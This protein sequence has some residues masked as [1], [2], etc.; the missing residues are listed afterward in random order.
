MFLKMLYFLQ[1]N[2]PEDAVFP[3]ESDI[4]LELH[5]Y[6]L[7]APVSPDIVTVVDALVLFP[8]TEIDVVF[9]IDE[10]D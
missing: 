5:T 2:V 1:V 9:C 8:V 3:S 6:I 4:E 10:H 7:P